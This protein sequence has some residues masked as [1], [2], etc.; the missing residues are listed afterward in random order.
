MLQMS[1]T[2]FVDHFNSNC[3]VRRFYRLLLCLKLV[4]GAW[5]NM[6]EWDNNFSVCIRGGSYGS[7]PWNQFWWTLEMYF[8]LLPVSW[9]L[10]TSGGCRREEITQPLFSTQFSLKHTGRIQKHALWFV[11]V[12]AALS[13]K[14]SL[15]PQ[16]DHPRWVS[17]APGGLPHGLTR[18]SSQVWKL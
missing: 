2:Q 15:R 17:H 11:S 14:A 12:K 9:V 16:V 3:T 4:T 8:S 7:N 10:I 18:L 1:V 5:L 6:Y 13:V